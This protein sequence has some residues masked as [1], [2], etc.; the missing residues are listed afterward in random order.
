[1]SPAAPEGAVSDRTPT[2][3]LCDDAA[4]LTE[5]TP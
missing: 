2:G 4:L 3:L 5:R 1:M